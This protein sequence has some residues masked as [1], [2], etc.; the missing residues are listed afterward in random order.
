MRA[1]TRMLLLAAAV[2]TMA[3]LQLGV[4]VA[5]AS[6]QTYCRDYDGF[7]STSMTTPVAGR[8]C[9]APSRD[10]PAYK[11]WA[12]VVDSP[13]TSIRSSVCGFSLFPYDIDDAI[14]AVG[15]PAVVP[16]PVPAWLWTADGWQRTYNGPRPGARV[17]VWPFGSGW[18][19][20]WFQNTWLAVQE[21]HV[22]LRWLIQR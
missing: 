22:A 7:R 2:T 11:G 15:C 1:R 3:V 18:R 14:P 6:A 19:W 5:P 16:D 21:D 10:Y 12:R 13:P 8:L 4:T 9:V 17:Y 20:V